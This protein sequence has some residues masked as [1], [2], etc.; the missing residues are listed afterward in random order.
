MIDKPERVFARGREWELLAEF[1]DEAGLGA[2]LGLVYGRRRQGKTFLLAGLVEAAGGLL[3]GATEQSSVQNLHAFSETYARFLGRP[4]TRFPDWPTAVDALWRLG[5]EAQRPVLVVLDE[6]GYLVDSVPG[7]ASLLQVSMDPGR[8]AYEHSRVRLVLCGSALTT[9]R[10][11]TG[12]SAPLRG[13]AQFN[14]TVHPFDYRATAAFWALEH[15]PELAFRMHALLGGTPA[16]RGMAGGSAPADLAE[17][18]AWVCRRLLDPNSVLMAEGA[19]LLHQQPDFADPSLYFSVLAAVSRGAHRTSEI[20]AA[21][22]RQ[23]TAIGHALAVLESV[24]FLAKDEDALRSRRPVYSVA[25]PVLRWHQLVVA[26]NDAPLAIGAAERVWRAASPTVASKI[27]GPH[28]EQLAREWTLAHASPDTLG[29]VP[30]SVRPATIACR[31]HRAGHELDVVAVQSEPFAGE[32]ILAIGEAKSTTKP[33]G[34]GELDRLRH[35]RD[36]LPADRQGP[37]ARLLLFSRSGFTRE[38][39]RTAQT[40]L[41]VELIDLARLYVGD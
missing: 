37:A 30:N 39:R 12:G 9:M 18:D 25:E 6:F 31:E 27:Y 1:A 28:F 23:P 3:F 8:W 15:Q 10:S 7:I 5:E 21:L 19:V 29:G 26:P 40:A 2:R 13:R 35:L 4:D 34:D 24:R 38:L 11:L 22:G 32:R 36:L 41:D 16:Y 14:L 20:A 17:F 33:V